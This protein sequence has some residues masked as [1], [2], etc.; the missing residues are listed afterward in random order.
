MKCNENDSL[1]SL[2]YNTSH[3]KNK[4]CPGSACITL[5][6]PFNLYPSKPTF[7]YK[8]SKTGVYRGVNYQIR[9][10][11][12]TFHPKI[13]IFIAVKPQHIVQLCLRNIRYITKTCPCYILQFFTAVK[14]HNFEMKNCDIFLIIAQNIDCGYTLEPPQ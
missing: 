13:D 1:N 12:S 7:I 2:W 10:E 3:H 14:K 6:H 9:K 5:K 4:D 8:F 11:I